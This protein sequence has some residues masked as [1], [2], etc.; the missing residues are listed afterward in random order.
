M[1]LPQTEQTPDDPKKLPPA[2]RR[3]A[4]RS[5]IPLNASERETFLE[6]LSHR[7]SPSFEFF[8]F[9]LLAGVIIC[10][11]LILDAPSLLVLGV[12]FAP[13]MA[14]IVGLSLGTITGST[15]FFVRSFVGVVFASFIFLLVGF[16]AGALAGFLVLAVGAVLT[17]IALVRTKRKVSF[18]SVALTY[19]LFI[20]LIV[21]GYGLGSGIPDLWPDGLVVFAIHLAWA[22]LLGAIT[23][24]FLGFRPL[25]LFGYT[26]GGAV[27]LVVGILVVGLSGAGA[28]FWGKVA[29]PTPIP[30]ATSTPTVT[31]TASATL[32]PSS[33]PVP[34][35]RTMPPTLTAT[36]TP[37]PTNTSPASP[38]PV[39]AIVNAPEENLG[40]V[41][42]SEMNFNADNVITSVLNGTLV[43]ILSE[44]PEVGEGGYLWLRVRI[45]GGPEGWMLAGLLLAATPAP[46]W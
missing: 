18:A 3:R 22:A 39:Y 20:P 36:I 45:P 17:T 4:K 33:T 37:S 42:R 9:S 11:G 8:W 13:T 26:I 15:R 43:E 7:V 19:E 10:I 34:P 12:L 5:L 24:A 46:N 30:T 38:T 28:A 6:E 31:F 35:T 23:L 40:A 25:T 21:A 44:K 1:N 41:L 14:P 16:L 29:I 2:R 27:I 32:T